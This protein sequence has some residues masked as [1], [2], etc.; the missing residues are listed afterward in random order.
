[1]KY[2]KARAYISDTPLLETHTNFS[3]LKGIN[4]RPRLET[5]IRLSIF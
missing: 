3:V 5:Y 2:K 4:Q 1:M